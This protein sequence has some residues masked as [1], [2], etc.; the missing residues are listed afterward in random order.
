[1]L[2]RLG[3]LKKHKLH[4]EDG[5]IGHVRDVYFDDVTWVVRY[6]VVDTGGWLSGRLVLLSPNAFSRP[7]DRER[8][9]S[10]TLTRDQI[11]HSPDVDTQ[12][13]VLRQHE[14]LLHLHYGWPYYWGEAAL[15]GVDV[16]GA[17][18][19][20]R[21][22]T[23]PTL[24]GAPSE[25][26]GTGQSPVEHNDPHLRSGEEVIGYAIAAKDGDIGHVDD[27]VIDDAGSFVRYLVAKTGTWLTGRE[28]LLAP[29]W[30]DALSWRDA[31]VRVGLDRD[32]IRRSP[33]IGPSETISREDEERLYRHYG[34][35]QYWHTDV[36]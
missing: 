23:D 25:T 19:L 3:K 24:T 5:E 33:E 34:R 17:Q 1:M 10:T 15:P 9:L 26:P 2:R 4:A 32:T 7:D 12:K 36:V 28:I 27:L 20:D 8:L 29:A 18:P 13:P 21:E 14:E 16:L 22:M 30:I 6:Y 31:H 11:R 35:T